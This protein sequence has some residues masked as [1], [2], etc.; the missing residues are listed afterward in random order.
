MKHVY[1]YETALGRIGIEEEG[2][3][4]TTL[5]LPGKAVPRDAK[6]EETAV[7]EMA[8]LQLREYLAG[9]R[10][11]FTVPLDPAGTP[12]MRSVWTELQRIPYGETRSYGQIAQAVGNRKACRAVGMRARWKLS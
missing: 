8:G 1:F 3:A 11:S 4:V 10:R 9:K 5:Y 12:F 6:I 2:G 7:L